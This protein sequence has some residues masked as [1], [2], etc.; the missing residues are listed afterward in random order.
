VSDFFVW[1]AVQ[2]EHLVLVLLA[3]HKSNWRC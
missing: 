2:P 3:K 1:Q